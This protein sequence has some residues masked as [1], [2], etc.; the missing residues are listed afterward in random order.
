MTMISFDM[1][2]NHFE[3]LELNRTGGAAFSPATIK[4]HQQQP[5]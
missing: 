1:E 4:S 3:L 5:I 2:L